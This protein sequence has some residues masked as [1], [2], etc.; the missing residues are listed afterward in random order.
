ML[1]SPWNLILTATF[2]VTA[3]WCIVDLVRHRRTRNETHDGLAHHTI[4][5]ANHLVMSVAMIVMVWVS[6]VDAATWA[7]IAVFAIFALALI[8]SLATQRVSD[9][10][11]TAAHIVLNAAMIWMLAAMPLLMAGMD[12]DA[13]EGGHHHGGGDESMLMATPGWADALNVVFIALS[14]AAALWWAVRL[15]RSRGRD[16]H[17]GCY[18]LM[19]AGMAVMLAVMNA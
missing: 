9:R 6:V 5:D 3:L 10:I 18:I 14:A 2:S 1:S 19:G 7:Q 4:V 13:G 17:D 11:S 12:M 8:P 16:L 15:I